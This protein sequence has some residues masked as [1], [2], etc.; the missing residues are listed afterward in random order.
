MLIPKKIIDNIDIAI[1]KFLNKILQIQSGLLQQ[2]AKSGMVQK[3]I[4]QSL[5]CPPLNDLVV[6]LHKR[7][8]I[9]NRLGI[10]IVDTDTMGRITADIIKNASTWVDFASGRGEFSLALIQRNCMLN[11]WNFEKRPDYVEVANNDRKLLSPEE[12]IRIRNIIGKIE[13][14][15]RGQYAS[16]GILQNSMDVVSLHCYEPGKISGQDAVNAMDYVLKSGGH[17]IITLDSEV[18]NYKKFL[19]YLKKRFSKVMVGNHPAE[20]PQTS[21]T[22]A[23]WH[24]HHEFPGV[25]PFICI[26]K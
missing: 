18:D 8:E 20:Y 11:I 15:A 14:V 12:S 22:F 3:K 2:A 25:P 24:R 7:Y 16:D 26:E 10:E 23:L 13:A 6:G 5:I 21:Y 17:A 4:M 9:A 1:T 19:K